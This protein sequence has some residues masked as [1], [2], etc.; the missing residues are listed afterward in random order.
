MQMQTIVIEQTIQDELT[1]PTMVAEA[2]HV[3]KR[4]ARKEG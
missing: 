4:H 1:L 2:M 3:R